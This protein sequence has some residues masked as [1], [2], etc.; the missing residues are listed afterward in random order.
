MVQTTPRAY[1]R[2]HGALVDRYLAIAEAHQATLRQQAAAYRL[3]QEARQASGCGWGA[4]GAALL[5]ALGVT[6]GF[7]RSSNRRASFDLTAGE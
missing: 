3:V 1:P 7:A 6:G 4:Q 2:T 5:A